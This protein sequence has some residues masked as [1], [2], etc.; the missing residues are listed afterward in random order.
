MGITTL[1]GI[2]MFKQK[3]TSAG[4]A[5][6]I[7]IGFVPE[8]I[9][10]TNATKWATDGTV[11]KSIFH[12]GM[13]EG[14]ALNEIADDSGINRSISTSDGFTMSEGADFSVNQSAVSAI[15]AANPPV[16]TVASTTGWASDNVVRLKNISGMTEVLNKDFKITVLNSTT[17]SLQDMQGNDIDGSAYT[18]YTASADDA[19]VNLSLDVENDGGVEVTLGTNIVGVSS[20]IMYIEAR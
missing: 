1:G 19:A 11:V 13:A 3:F 9:E 16:V 6:T 17:F 20:D 10:V 7:K 18:A 4:T 8:T 12:K 14:Y 2:N 5:K 15:T